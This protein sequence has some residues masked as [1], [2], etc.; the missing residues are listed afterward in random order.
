MPTYVIDND[1]DYSG[2]ELYF[3]EGDF[4]IDVAR[5]LVEPGDKVVGV[6]E[7]MEWLNSD[8]QKKMARE[9]WIFLSDGTPRLEDRLTA[10]APHMGIPIVKVLVERELEHWKKVL[11]HLS[12]PQG[13]NKPY[14]D[15]KVA[16]IARLEEWLGSFR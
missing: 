11:P 5:A 6:A 16:N 1:G 10:L 15:Q 7:E 14:Y 12:D 4:Q 2:W 3:M 8:S 13:K 9:P